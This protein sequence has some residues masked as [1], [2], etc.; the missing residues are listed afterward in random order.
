MASYQMAHRETGVILSGYV[1][2]SAKKEEIK[3]AN[4]RLHDSLSPWKYLEVLDQTCQ[5]SKI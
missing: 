4:Q 2:K 1:I 3:A 5:S